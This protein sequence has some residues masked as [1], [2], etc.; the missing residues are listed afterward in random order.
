MS[1]LLSLRFHESN[2]R[3]T[4][5]LDAMKLANPLSEEYVELSK[6]AHSEIE[7]MQAINNSS[8]Q[9]LMMHWTTSGDFS[10]LQSTPGVSF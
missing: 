7:T 9:Q 1:K 5:L 8:L 4:A 3:M 6:M 10:H 2:Q